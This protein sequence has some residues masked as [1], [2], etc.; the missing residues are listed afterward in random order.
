MCRIR[1]LLGFIVGS[2]LIGCG[3]G[4]GQKHQPS[5][6]NIVGYARITINWFNN[7]IDTSSLR[8]AGIYQGI[9]PIQ[10]R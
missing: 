3:G 6:P 4:G 1:M 9:Y 7:P 5:R 8:G 2:I 10:Q